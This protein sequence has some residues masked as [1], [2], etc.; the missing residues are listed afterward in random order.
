MGSHFADSGFLTAAIEGQRLPTVKL[1]WE[2]DTPVWVSQW[3][4]T[5]DKLEPL[6]QLVEEQLKLGHIKPSFS[7]WNTPIFVIK[8][9][10][11][12]WRLLHD[13]R[14]VNAIMK[15]MGALQPG[16]PSPVALPKDW[17]L[18]IVDLKDF[19]FSIPLHPS[20]TERFAFSVPQKNTCRP[21]PR[22]EWVVLPQGMRNSPTICQ[23][24]V[25]LALTKWK[26][27]YPDVIVYH[28]MDDILLAREQ[29]I[30]E[31]MEQYLLECL[32][33]YGLQVAPEKVQRNSPWLY[34]GMV[35][36]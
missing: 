25:D 12:K 27:K 2:S 19:F 22:Y 18:L 20:D 14:A 36:T 6:Q 17:N 15:P 7:E 23:W 10:S 21:T 5:E 30:V 24:Y 1:Q 34:L 4:L 31:A 16:L 9:K 26:L 32:A 3:P 35:V 29:E 28:Y 13:L 11:G 33:E 8:K